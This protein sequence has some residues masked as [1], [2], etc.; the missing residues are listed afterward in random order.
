M[1]TGKT[2]RYFKYAIGEIILVVIGILIALQINTWNEKRKD[3]I[4][5]TI[6][7]SS[8]VNDLKNDSIQMDSI[9]RFR[10]KLKREGELLYEEMKLP[11]ANN[12]PIIDSLYVS[13]Q[14]RN[15]T[16]FP[17]IG[18]YDGA[19]NSGTFENLKN[20]ALKQQIRNLYERYYERL[21][22]NGQELDKRKEII[23]LNRHRFFDE[24]DGKI[25][26]LEAIKDREF[27]AQLEFLLYKNKIYIELLEKFLAEINA[28]LIQIELE[29]NQND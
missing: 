16:F 13:V 8:L 17:T 5:S 26:S 27:Y 7:L 9:L 24:R 21:I 18:V 19:K 23:A 12:K 3:Q 29:L 6:F 28:T 22:Y 1:E 14:D 4:K 15:P 2:T 20:E 10:L 11:S 25:I